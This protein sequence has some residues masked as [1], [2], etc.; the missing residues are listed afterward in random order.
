MISPFS[1]HFGPTVKP[2]KKYSDNVLCVKDNTTLFTDKCIIPVHIDTLILQ[3]YNLPLRKYV[4]HEL[5]TLPS[6]I[7]IIKIVSVAQQLFTCDLNVKIVNREAFNQSLDYLP[8][9]L[10]YLKINSYTY[11]QPLDNLPINLKCLKINCKLI[12]DI[13]VSYLHNLT[14][15][16]SYTSNLISIPESVVHLKIRKPNQ[17]K[18]KVPNVKILEIKDF[19]ETAPFG[20]TSMPEFGLIPESV[21][22]LIFKKLCNYNILNNLPPSVLKIQIPCEILKYSF[23]FIN[24][25]PP[26]LQSFR[27]VFSEQSVNYVAGLKE[28]KVDF[29]LQEQSINKQ[30][31]EDLDIIQRIKLPNDCSFLTNLFL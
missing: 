1:N 21:E 23:P 18:I 28:K 4:G 19:S 12:G 20:A 10:E 29:T 27:V 25:L 22:I 7:K 5:V 16:E 24:N 9:N 8:H 2:E 30:I 31:R 17:I 26:M 11:K 14:K 3:Q 15:L 13:D 6:N